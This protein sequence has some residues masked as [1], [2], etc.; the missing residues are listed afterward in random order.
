MGDVKQVLVAVGSISLSTEDG[1]V[2]TLVAGGE[3]IELSRLELDCLASALN[4]Y[5]EALE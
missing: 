2:H 1:D 5:F 3:A 4:S